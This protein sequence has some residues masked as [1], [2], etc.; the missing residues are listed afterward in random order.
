MD[1]FDYVATTN[2]VSQSTTTYAS[3]YTVD[4]AIDWINN[5]SGPWLAHVA[6]W[7]FPAHWPPAHL[8]TQ[9]AADVA[10]HT[11]YQQ[12]SRPAQRKRRQQQ[13]SHDVRTR[14]WL[15]PQHSVILKLATY[16]A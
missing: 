16:L 12:F 2:G 14:A 5:T 1:Y 11:Q 7:S 8:H 3:T 4:A 6:F 15:T 13:Q 10:S 9:Y